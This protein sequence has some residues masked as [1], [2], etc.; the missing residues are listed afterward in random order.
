MVLFQKKLEKYLGIGLVVVLLGT[1]P[2][3]DEVV[4]DAVGQ[5]E[6][7]VPGGGDISILDEGVVQM[8]VEGLL[9]VRDVLDVDDA[10]NRDLLSLLVIGVAHRHLPRGLGTLCTVRGTNGFTKVR[11]TRP[12]LRE[13][14]WN[15][16]GPMMNV[17]LLLQLPARLSARSTSP[18]SPVSPWTRS[19][20]RVNFR[21]S[22]AIRS[23]FCVYQ[24]PFL[25]I[26][27]SYNVGILFLWC[28]LSGTMD[29][30]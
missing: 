27:A 29:S 11:I 10:P 30:F 17:R 18:R 12:S 16:A 23:D 20:M 15:S 25:R 5:G 26:M 7:V 2:P 8:P 21:S 13:L 6:V 19:R 1:N 24:N 22:A 14:F 3:W 28:S 4:L 9:E